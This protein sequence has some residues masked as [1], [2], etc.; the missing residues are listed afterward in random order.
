MDYLTYLDYL[1]IIWKRLNEG[2]SHYKKNKQ[3][4]NSYD[5]KIKDETIGPSTPSDKNVYLAYIIEYEITKTLALDTE[6][7]IFFSRIFLNKLATMLNYL[8]CPD[9]YQTLSNDFQVHKNYFLNN[10]NINKDYTTLLSKI[11][12]WYDQYLVIYRNKVIQHS[13]TLNN[14]YMSNYE[15]EI[16][17]GKMLGIR[18]IPKEDISQL[19][20]IKNKLEK[21][22]KDLKITNNQT[23]MLDDLIAKIVK[24]SI[25]LEQQDLDYISSL[26]SKVGMNINPS[27]I[28]Q[29][30]DRF[31]IDTSSLF[32]KN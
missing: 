10:G 30:L 7:F 4:L 17:L 23:M 25:S 13:S 21:K 31:V 2:Y 6:S 32:K 1:R 24:E 20:K 16:Q 3:L 15:G 14:T 5:E 9:N 27:I 29:S 19:N 18:E 11:Y 8:F 26:I 28:A 12:V 22:F